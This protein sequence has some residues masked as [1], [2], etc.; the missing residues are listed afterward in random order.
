MGN[1]GLQAMD[2]RAINAIVFRLS[3]VR[4]AFPRTRALDARNLFAVD[5]KADARIAVVRAV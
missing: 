1:I 3:F 5:R 2:T 4:R